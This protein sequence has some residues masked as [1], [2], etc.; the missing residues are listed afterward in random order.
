LR[1]IVDGGSGL[2]VSG[3]VGDKELG[4]VE[5]EN[6]GGG[7]EETCQCGDAK[8]GQLPKETK[9]PNQEPPA[10]S[11]PPVINLNFSTLVPN[12]EEARDSIAE[13]LNKSR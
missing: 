6:F 4:I 7:G 2:G 12:K 10:S 11:H 8:P 5:S 9:N 3:V 1:E 13:F